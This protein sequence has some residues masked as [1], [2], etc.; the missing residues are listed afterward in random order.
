MSIAKIWDHGTHIEV[1]PRCLVLPMPHFMAVSHDSDFFA[2]GAGTRAP[3]HLGLPGSLCAGNAKRREEGVAH[4]WFVDKKGLA[5][6][7]LGYGL[8]WF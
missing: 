6:F 5:A 4:H 2:P 7:G 8:D 3:Q 1:M